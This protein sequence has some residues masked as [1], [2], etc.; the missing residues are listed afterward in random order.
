MYIYS[1]DTLK[2]NK[3]EYE[4]NFILSY[5]KRTALSDILSDFVEVS[6]LRMLGIRKA[7]DLLVEKGIIITSDE[8]LQFVNTEEDFKIYK[9]DDSEPIISFSNKRKSKAK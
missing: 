3:S 8:L 1:K 2:K 4:N 5:E 6:P 9:N 7:V